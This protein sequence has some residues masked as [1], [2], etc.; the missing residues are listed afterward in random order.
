MIMV[1]HEMSFARKVSS[2]LLFLHQGRVEEQGGAEILD[3]PRS[4]R[5][6]QFLSNGL[7]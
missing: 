4:E 3:N 7:K 2:Q 6:Q 1:T 5:L